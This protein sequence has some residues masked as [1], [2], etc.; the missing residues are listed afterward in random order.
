MSYIAPY[1]PREE[2]ANA[3]T[4][5]IGFL[6]AVA[7]LVYMIN[8]A[9]LQLSAWQKAG[10]V[11]YAVSL[12]LMFL[13][14][15]LYHAVSHPKAKTVLKRLDHCAIYLLIAGS[16]TPLLTIPIE[17]PSAKA[18]LIVIW[19]MALVGVG[20][21]A[22]FAG[23]FKWISTATY[24]LMGWLSVVVIYPLYQA[25]ATPGFLLLVVGG[26]AY[27]VGVIFYVNQKIPFNHAIWHC[28]VVMGAVS[29]CWLV[30]KYVL[31]GSLI[32]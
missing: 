11:V 25:L 5:G 20:F 32:S 10:V 3:L 7:A 15:T 23:R 22:F 6:F 12:I 9:P 21:K 27:T 16:F 13:V 14:S 8:V 29:H 24:L 31:N 30:V 2:L 28:F 1:S 26:V 18:V 19:S 4:H 17:T